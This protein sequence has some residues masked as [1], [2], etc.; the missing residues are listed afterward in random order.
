VAG[1]LKVPFALFVVLVG[2]GKCLRYVALSWA[3]LAI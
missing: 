3:V 1:M 2:I